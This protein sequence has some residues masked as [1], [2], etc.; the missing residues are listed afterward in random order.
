[1]NLFYRLVAIENMGK[2]FSNNKNVPLVEFSHIIAND[3]GAFSLFDKANLDFLM[4]VQFGIE[5]FT[6]VLLYD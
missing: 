1:M 6:L 2:V 5:L 4:L 3:K